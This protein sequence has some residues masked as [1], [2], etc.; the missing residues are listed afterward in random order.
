MHPTPQK[1]RNGHSAF[2]PRCPAYKAYFRLTPDNR[3]RVFFIKRNLPAEVIQLH[4]GKGLF[5]MPF[6]L[7]L[8]PIV[9]L[10]LGLESFKII[11]GLYPIQ[12]DLEFI[13]VDF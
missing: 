10:K 11:S 7:E 5:E 6:A 1:L 12:E 2:V 13:S 8:P 3:V 9:L 4:F